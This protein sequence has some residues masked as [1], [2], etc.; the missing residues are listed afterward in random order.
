MYKTY[1]C[2]DIKATVYT[3]SH[4]KEQNR[5][6]PCEFFHYCH[7]LFT[8]LVSVTLL[9]TKTYVLL[10]KKNQNQNDVHKHHPRAVTR[11]QKSF[12][13]MDDNKADVCNFQIL[14]ICSFSTK[15]INFLHKII[16]SFLARKNSLLKTN[17]YNKG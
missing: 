10:L 14:E 2:N 8:C 3:P 13:F 7:G 6:L 4:R 15:I 11:D 5:L 16:F 12:L 1:I 17:V 9:R